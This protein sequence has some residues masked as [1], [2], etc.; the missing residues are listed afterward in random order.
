MRIAAAEKALRDN[1]TV[2]FNQYL[3]AVVAGAFLAMVI[4]IVVICLYEWARLLSG[5]RAPDLKETPPVWLPE[6]AVI[7]GGRPLNTVGAAALALALAKELSGE[8][9]LD[10]I[11]A[12]QAAICCE[13]HRQSRDQIYVQTMEE[14]YKSIRRCC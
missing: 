10:R 4:A 6:Y 12:Q 7:E 1:K 13:D 11:A 2:A 14:R 8:A 9:E 5:A 3:D